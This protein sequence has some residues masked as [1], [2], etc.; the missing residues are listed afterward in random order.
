MGGSGEGELR[1]S[2]GTTRL[3]SAAQTQESHDGTCP[4]GGETDVIS[5]SGSVATRM[6]LLYLGIKAEYKNLFV[7][8][9]GG[10]NWVRCMYLPFV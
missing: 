7:Q 5:H 6:E 10:V 2:S 9:G 1:D 8:G 4:A 3:V